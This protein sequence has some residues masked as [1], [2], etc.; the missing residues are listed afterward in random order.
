MLDVA[1]NTWQYPDEQDQLKLGV[2]VDS[3]DQSRQTM[4]H[5]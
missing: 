1:E 2:W 4:L 5:G 3:H